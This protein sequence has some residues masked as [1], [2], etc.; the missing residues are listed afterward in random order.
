[1]EELTVNKPTFY[2]DYGAVCGSNGGKWYE[3]TLCIDGKT[4]RID[5]QLSL[6]LVPFTNIF[7]IIGGEWRKIGQ[8]HSRGIYRFK[9]F[10]V[11]DVQDLPEGVLLAAG[12]VQGVQR[13]EGVLL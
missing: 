11:V 13:L 6:E 1:M 10:P 5:A 12:I 2:T 4:W 9:G 8:Y 7:A 3:K